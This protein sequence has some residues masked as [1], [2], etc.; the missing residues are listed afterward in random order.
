MGGCLDHPTTESLR[1]RVRP[2]PTPDISFWPP[3]FALEAGGSRVGRG[4]RPFHSLYLAN[5]TSVSQ[6]VTESVSQLEPFSRCHCYQSLP[7]RL[8]VYLSPPQT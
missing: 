8:P 2:R 4:E 7:A 1:R 5:F 6:S 3:N